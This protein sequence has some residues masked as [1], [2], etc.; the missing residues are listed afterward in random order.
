VI[1]QLREIFCNTLGI[2]EKF[3]DEVVDKHANREILIKDLNGNW[4]RKDLFRE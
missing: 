1:R 4:R 2:T 3:F